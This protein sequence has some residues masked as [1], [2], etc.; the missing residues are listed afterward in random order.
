GSETLITRD[1]LK[2]RA[3]AI[4]GADPEWSAQ[5]IYNFVLA[6]EVTLQMTPQRTSRTG[7]GG[8]HTSVRLPDGRAAL[9]SAVAYSL[10]SNGFDLDGNPRDNISVLESHELAEAVTDP[11]FADGSSQRSNV[12]GWVT[13]AGDE[14]AD[15]TMN[16]EPDGT[17]RAEM[18]DR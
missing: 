16:D 7:L 1:D 14:L 13:D 5:L 6:P 2:A 11:D 12:L 17:P 3:A 8:L 4:A 18:F 9:L 10:G 15:L